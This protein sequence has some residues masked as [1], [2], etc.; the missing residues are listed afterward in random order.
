ME[1]LIRSIFTKFGVTNICSDSRCLK[2]GEAFF[3][4]KGSAWDGNQFI[5][6]AL[7]KGCIAFTDDQKYQEEKVFI[8]PDIRLGLAIASGIIYPDLPAN[9]IAV[10]GTNGKSSVVSYVFQLLKLL[11]QE[12]ASMGTIGVSSTKALDAEFLADLSENLTTSDPLTFRKLLHTIANLGIDNVVFEASS[13]GLDQKRLGN[14]KLKSAGFSSFS[15]DHLDYHHSMEKYLA[16]KLSLF[17]N[18]LAPQCEAVINSE[19]LN[20]DY[21]NQ[22]LEFLNK[23]S[24][25]YSSVGEDGYIQI[26]FI[27]TSITGS[28]VHFFYRNKV[29]QFNTEIIGSFQGVNLLMAARLV[30]NLDYD[31]NRI[32]ELIPRLEAVLGRLQRVGKS[33]D[34]FHIFID[35]AHTPDALEKTLTELKKIKDKAG[36]LYVIFG[37]GGNRDESK[38]PIMGKIAANL[39]DHVIITDDNPRRENAASI[40]ADILASAPHAEEI[41]DRRNAIE[42]IL[43]KLGKNDILLIAGKGHE[44]YQIIGDEK[45]PFS[46]YKIAYNFLQKLLKK[47]TDIK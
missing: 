20:G 34:P 44:D 39:A 12:A 24:I 16:A 13:H 31:F 26:K 1:E 40:R 9:L 37:C 15:Q 45:I 21:G 42:N 8:L 19:I 35:Y 2:Q 30:S 29:Y 23:N 17:T 10:T 25:N 41:P 5:S 33:T 7:Q 3:A 6:E 14:I 38:R 28:D 32:I 18:N 4:I 46:D 11:G 36:K 22:V 43:A 27:N 47:R